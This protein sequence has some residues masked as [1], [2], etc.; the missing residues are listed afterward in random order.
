MSI[1]SLKDFFGLLGKLEFV[2]RITFCFVLKMHLRLF[3]KKSPV[4]L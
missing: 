1:D 4:L 2:D 3:R